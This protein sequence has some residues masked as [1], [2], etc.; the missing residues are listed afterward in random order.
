MEEKS[1]VC[2]GGW[3]EQRVL[4]ERLEGESAEEAGGAV[5]VVPGAVLE[6]HGDDDEEG[7]AGDG[8][9]GDDPWRPEAV[10]R[11]DC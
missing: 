6:V 4:S 2:G 10:V 7:D 3:A 5:G 8:G 9:S 11:R 1:A